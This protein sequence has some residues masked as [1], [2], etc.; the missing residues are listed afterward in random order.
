LRGEE[1]PEDQRHEGGPTHGSNAIGV[2]VWGAYDGVLYWMCP[3]CLGTWL[4]WPREDFRHA[5]AE[6]Y[7]T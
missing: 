2:E 7:V 5:R 6:K 4:R 3:A 1:I